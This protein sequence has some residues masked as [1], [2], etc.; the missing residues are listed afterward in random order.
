MLTCIWYSVSC[1]ECFNWLMYRSILHWKSE[2]TII[3]LLLEEAIANSYK[4]IFFNVTFC[5]QKKKH[6]RIKNFFD[7]FQS[8]FMVWNLN[9][10]L[11]SIFFSFYG[12]KF[13]LACELV[14]Y[15]SSVKITLLHL[16]KYISKVFQAVSYYVMCVLIIFVNRVLILL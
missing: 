16:Q 7:I 12:H 4:Y 10:F 2:S 14:T 11:Y 15:L 13:Y 5:I 9:V 6:L 3:S 8:H 1:I